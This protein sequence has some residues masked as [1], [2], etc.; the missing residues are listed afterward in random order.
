MIFKSHDEAIEFFAELN[1]KLDFNC[2]NTL[3]EPDEVLKLHKEVV[4]EC[5]EAYYDYMLSVYNN[6]ELQEDTV[7]ISTVLGQIESL[8]KML[9]VLKLKVQLNNL[10]ELHRDLDE[11]PIFDGSFENSIFFAVKSDELKDLIRNMRYGGFENVKYVFSRIEE[12]F[13]DFKTQFGRIMD[14]FCF[15]EFV[16]IVHEWMV[17]A[18]L[19]YKHARRK[20]QMHFE[21]TGVISKL[22]I[23]VEWDDLPFE[24]NRNL[25]QE[26]NSCWDWSYIEAQLVKDE[27]TPDTT[28]LTYTPLIEPVLLLETVNNAS[29]VFRPVEAPLNN[30]LLFGGFAEGVEVVEPIA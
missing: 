7:K 29:C 5:I 25:P 27:L 8:S 14:E 20:M 22:Y 6:P 28:L 18:E 15:Y 12:S 26:Y 16:E 3:K 24:F 10:A 13:N 9:S 17:E 1:G 11:D 2:I 30:I 23:K 21:A 4:E 19:I